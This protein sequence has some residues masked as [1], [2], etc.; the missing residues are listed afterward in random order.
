MY[1]LF[2]LGI[3]EF[4][5]LLEVVKWVLCRVD[6]MVDLFLERVFCL[7][8]FMFFVDFDLYKVVEWLLLFELMNKKKK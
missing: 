2:N 3:M 5:K 8:I 6:M 1:R 4:G 7:I